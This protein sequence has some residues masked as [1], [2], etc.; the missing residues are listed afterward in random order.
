[1]WGVQDR[2]GELRPPCF[3]LWQSAPARR[4]PLQLLSTKASR[5]SLLNSFQHRAVHSVH[6]DEDIG[7]LMI[8]AD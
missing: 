7:G 6:N 8:G 4:K 5:N 1:M 2:S 3:D